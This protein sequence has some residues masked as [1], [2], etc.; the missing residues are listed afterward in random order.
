MLR[1]PL[2]FVCLV[3]ILPLVGCSRNEPLYNVAN[4]SVPAIQDRLSYEQVRAAIVKALVDNGWSIRQQT[5]DNISALISFRA[6]SASIAI[7]YS[8]SNYSIMY[9]NSNNLDYDG[10]SIHRNYNKQIMDLERA[11]NGNLAIVQPEAWKIG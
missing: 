10:S 7:N 3:A 6:H 11:I 5:P 1:L 9:R 4:A 8:Q 2:L